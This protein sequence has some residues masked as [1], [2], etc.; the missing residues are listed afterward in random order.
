MKKITVSKREYVE[1]CLRSCRA[2]RA[3]DW[4]YID[5]DDGAVLV[6][7]MDRGPNCVCVGTADVTSLCLDIERYDAI[8]QVIEN[9]DVIDGWDQIAREAV[10]DEDD[11]IIEW[12]C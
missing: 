4:I 11:V 5:L 7:W 3:S 8:E 6:G 10:E 2:D 12:V 9:M 1:R